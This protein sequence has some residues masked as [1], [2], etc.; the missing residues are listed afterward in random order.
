MHPKE[1]TK[2]DVFKRR[3]SA[4]D[5]DASNEGDVKQKCRRTCNLQFEVVSGVAGGGVGRD[6]GALPHP[7]IFF[8]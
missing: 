4:P 3:S 1:K 6:G 5:A 7:I 2:E 8:V